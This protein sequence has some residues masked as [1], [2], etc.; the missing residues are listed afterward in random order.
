MKRRH[1]QQELE[2][3]AE[4]IPNVDGSGST[5]PFK[6]S[7]LLKEER[8]EVPLAI[9]FF[10]YAIAAE[11]PAESTSAPTTLIAAPTPV[12]ASPSTGPITSVEDTSI[13]AND[14]GH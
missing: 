9:L 7:F 11:A 1:L 2:A 14:I 12:A 8:K 3:Q 4:P 10:I 13:R 5:Q 6:D